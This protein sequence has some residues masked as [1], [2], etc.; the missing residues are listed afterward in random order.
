MQMKMSPGAGGDKGNHQIKPKGRGSGIMVSDFVCEKDGFLKL[1]DVGVEQ[2]A[3]QTLEYGEQRDGYWTKDKFISQMKKAERIASL[4]YPDA[5]VLWVFDNAPQHTARAVDS[6]DAKKMNKGPSGAQP[7]MRDTVWD[8][9]PQR[10]V[11]ANGIPK[12][13][14]RVLQERGVD[15]RGK[16]KAELAD[17]IS[18][19]ADFKSEGRSC[20]LP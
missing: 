13:L 19:H 14:E 11:D 5:T 8:G 1:F 12:G 4:K 2:A 9:Q 17:I 10:M 7:K 16:K 18:D 3:R 15:T 20:Q 6:L